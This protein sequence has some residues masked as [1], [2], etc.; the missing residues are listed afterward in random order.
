[1]AVHNNAIM[2]I[3]KKNHLHRDCLPI[4]ILLYIILPLL[5]LIA[6]LFDA[7][8]L[9]NAYFLPLT[10]AKAFCFNALSWFIDTWFLYF[11][12]YFASCTVILICRF[13]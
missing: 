7:V 6:A 11:K 8:C 5:L 1:M 9:H 3:K 10:F 4:L 13:S 2:C 12:Y